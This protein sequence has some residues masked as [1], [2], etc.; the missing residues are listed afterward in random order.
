MVDSAARS[1][2]GALLLETGVVTKEQHDQAVAAQKEQGGELIDILF[3]LGHIDP[4]VVADFLQNRPST[5]PIDFRQ[6]ELQPELVALLPAKLA[7]KYEVVPIDS[8]AGALTLGS[9]AALPAEAVRELEDAVGSRV[10]TLRC[11]PE[12]R[13][14]RHRALLPTRGCGGTFGGGH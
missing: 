1:K 7:R 8:F 10:R 9:A 3:S 11:H 4:Q 2:I 12:E 5:V 13:A 6:L 14:H